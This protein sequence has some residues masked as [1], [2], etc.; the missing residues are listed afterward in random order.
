[1]EDVWNGDPKYPATASCPHA[2]TIYTQPN[3]YGSASLTLTFLRCIN[4]VFPSLLPDSSKFKAFAMT[5][6][7]VMQ[8]ILASP[9][10]RVANGSTR[11]NQFLPSSYVPR[12]P[13]NSSVRVRSMS[14][15]RKISSFL[16][17]FSQVKYYSLLSYL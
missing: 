1:M 13:R 6:S 8:S 12:L 16:S 9:L 15:V 4:L 5:T 17:Y 3:S 14:K 7:A 2:H 10:T 11:V